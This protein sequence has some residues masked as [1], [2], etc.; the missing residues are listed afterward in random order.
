MVN[1]CPAD[2]WIVVQYRCTHQT[3]H[4]APCAVFIVVV[5]ESLNKDCIIYLKFESVPYYHST[6][7]RT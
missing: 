5:T 1:L 7:V 6:N 4:Q 2:I 3:T